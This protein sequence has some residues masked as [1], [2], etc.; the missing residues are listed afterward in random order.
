MKDALALAKD[1]FGNY[2]IQKIL[3]VGLQSHK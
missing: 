1:A 3:E 2:V